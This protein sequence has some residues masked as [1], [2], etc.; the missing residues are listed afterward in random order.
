[1]CGR[2]PDR[3][4]SRGTWEATISILVVD[5][6]T[7]SVRAAL[8]RPDGS[9][10]QVTRQATPPTVPFPGLV[11]FDA[12]AMAAA[13]LE[14]ARQAL[15]TGGPVDAVGIATQRASTVAWDPTTGRALG[16]G[17]GWQDLRTA[18]TCLELQAE[19]IRLSPSESATKYAWLLDN[20]DLSRQGGTRL[21]TVDSWIAW[22]LSG[23]ELHVTDPG[24]AATTGLLGER[25]TEWRTDL[26]ERLGIPPGSLP[27][28]VPSSAAIGTA[29]ALPGAPPI[30]GIAGDQQASLIGQS[31]TRSGLAKATFG[32]GAMLDV[33]VGDRP[34][35]ATRG[36]GGCFPIVAWSRGGVVTWGV[37]AI[38][39]AAGSTVDW[40]VEDLGVL[41][42]AEESAVVAAGC[43]DTGGVVMVPAFSGLGTP[44]WDFGARGALLGLTRG[45]GRAQLVRAVLEGVAHRGADL[46]EA[47]E[48]DAGTAIASLR[49]DGGMT[50]NPVFV[51][52]LADACS[53]PVELSPQLE[54]TTLGAGYLAGLAVG[55]WAD[56]EEIAA[57][58]APRGIIE[59]AATPD[60]ERWRSSVARAAQWY[61]ELTAVKF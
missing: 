22:H 13:A 11:E 19:G 44:A 39:L 26:A 58:W 35:F 12:D 53:R 21:G 6:G 46:L 20:H 48:H 3:R 9:V 61:P 7:S 41:R 28:I 2:V 55:T 37:E 36:E 45:S 32:T 29:S 18:G 30:C 42:S 56:E 59:P 10:D 34:S 51:Q 5:V 4:R 31:C 50:A 57:A 14:V 1:V 17:I 23:G 8:V 38:M 54:A 27:R 24:N 47:A 40:L 43:D 52:S 16:P 25:A 60:R 49:V 15:A 33:C